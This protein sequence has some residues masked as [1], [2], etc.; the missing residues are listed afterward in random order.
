MTASHFRELH[1]TSHRLA[2]VNNLFA[3]EVCIDVTAKSLKGWI[4]SIANANVTLE[5]K[6]L[7]LTLATE[8][9][10][11]LKVISYHNLM[12]APCET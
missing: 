6:T 11:C 5:R 2:A 10:P 9:L 3:V 1:E 4:N 8:L 12:R 7:T